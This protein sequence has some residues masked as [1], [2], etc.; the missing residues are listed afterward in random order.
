MTMMR[1]LITAGCA[2]ALGTAATAQTDTLDYDDLGGD[3]GYE[4]TAPEEYDTYGDDAGQGFGDEVDTTTLRVLTPEDADP[5]A[6]E[7]DA[8]DPYAT[9]PDE[10]EDPYDPQR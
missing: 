9:D 1:F 6:T 7:P 8:V 4:Q 5:N 2:L 3:A 10:G